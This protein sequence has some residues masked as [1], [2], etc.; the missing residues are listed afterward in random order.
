MKQGGRGVLGHS[1]I[2]GPRMRLATSVEYLD[3]RETSTFDATESMP[4]TTSRGNRAR[5]IILATTAI[6]AALPFTHPALAVVA[7]MIGRT[8]I[9]AALPF[10]P[11]ALA[12][13]GDP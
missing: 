1:V 4:W 12:Q 2:L 11:P 7:R 8:A 6:V 10:T 13:R 9:V 5:P 3:S